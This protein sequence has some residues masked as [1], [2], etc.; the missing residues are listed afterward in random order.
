[1]LKND[2]RKSGSDFI[3]EKNNKEN[4]LIIMDEKISVKITEEHYYKN[5]N[6]VLEKIYDHS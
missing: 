4:V 3:I 2:R 6:G 1:M 5:T